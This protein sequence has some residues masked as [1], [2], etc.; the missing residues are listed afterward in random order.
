MRGTYGLVSQG[1]IGNRRNRNEME[2]T[3]IYGKAEKYSWKIKILPCIGVAVIVYYIEL[4][5]ELL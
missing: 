2:S 1:G 3:T 5:T 4:L